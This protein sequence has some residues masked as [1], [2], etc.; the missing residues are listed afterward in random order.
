MQIFIYR[1]IVLH[2]SGVHRAHRQKY[3]KLQLQP[4]VQI[5][6]SGKQT[7]SNVTKNGV[8]IWS[9]LEKLAPQTV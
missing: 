5:K 1:Y 4:L 2:V 3:I 9:R 6:L 7:S 8:R